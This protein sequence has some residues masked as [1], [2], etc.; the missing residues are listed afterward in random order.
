MSIAEQGVEGEY[1]RGKVCFFLINEDT[2]EECRVG[3]PQQS[4]LNTNADNF[5][6][7]AATEGPEEE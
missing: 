5:S 7:P 6:W 3:Q 4:K 2:E 1:I